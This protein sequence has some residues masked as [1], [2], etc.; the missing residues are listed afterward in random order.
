[1]STN[2]LIYIDS[3]KRFEPS[4]IQTSYPYSNLTNYSTFINNKANEIFS[5][6]AADDSVNILE[7]RKEILDLGILYVKIFVD[8]A[9][10][11]RAIS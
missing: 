1:M 10:R 2:Y 3:F 9:W 8:F 4:A 5:V 6:A 11:K 7:L